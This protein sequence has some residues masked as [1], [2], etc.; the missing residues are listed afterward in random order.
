MLENT[1][2]KKTAEDVLESYNVLTESTKG[3]ELLKAITNDPIST[4]FSTNLGRGLYFRQRYPRLSEETY[5]AVVAFYD[6]ADSRC[7]N[8]LTDMQ[9]IS[10]QASTNNIGQGTVSKQSSETKLDNEL[11]T[12]T[13][14]GIDDFMAQKVLATAS[15]GTFQLAT[16]ATGAMINCSALDL[17]PYINKFLRAKDSGG[18]YAWGYPK[19][20]GGGEALG[21]AKAITGITKAN[22]GV[23]TFQ[24]GHG[25]V[26]GELVKFSGLTEM[27]ELNGKY[28]TL[29]NKSGDTFTIGNTSTFGAA[30]TTGGNCV[31]QVITIAATGVTIVSTL[32]GATQSWTGQETGFLPNAISTVEM[33]EPDFNITDALTV[34]MWVK[35][36]DGQ[37]A[38]ISMP[39]A[40]WDPN[41]PANRSWI[42]T[43]ETTGQLKFWVGSEGTITQITD[44]AFFSN[45]TQASFS[46]IGF[47]YSAS[48]QT[49]TF[50]GNGAVLASTVV[51]G[52]IPASL[53]DSSNLFS[54]GGSAI[55]TYP[56]AGSIASAMIFSRALSAAEI[57]NIYNRDKGRF[58]K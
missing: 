15:T 22:P 3:L 34:L 40:K 52:T 12:L 50:Y 58:E 37:P 16:I 20:V 43:L 13:F 48:A 17:S 38:T 55:G 42:V 56:F 19:A 14:D 35:P 44:T 51:G 4:R 10:V 49:V 2:A 32:G 57:A 46:Q 36:D 28:R 6:F 47:V 5:N 8:D 27:T 24:A 45:G 23:V 21:S 54:V 31:Q 11:K 26:N 25:F 39:S 29:V 9:D 7:V 41:A 33:L 30:E 18:K 1:Q 53:F